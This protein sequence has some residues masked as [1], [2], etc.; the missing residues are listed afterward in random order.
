MFKRKIE[1]QKKFRA[2]LALF[3]DENATK[4]ELQELVMKQLSADAAANVSLATEDMTATDESSNKTAYLFASA[5]LITAAAVAFTLSKKTEEK[6]NE[7]PLLSKD[8][9]IAH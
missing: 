4:A 8:E 2:A 6:S 9:I 5:S 7:V 3:M 1:E